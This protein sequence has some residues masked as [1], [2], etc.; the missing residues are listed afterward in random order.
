MKA[1]ILSLIAT[2]VSIAATEAPVSKL[3]NLAADGAAVAAPYNDKGD[4]LPDFSHAGYG[5]G[6][7][8][9]PQVPVAIT[10]SPAP[11]DNRARIQAAL[12]SLAARAPDAEGW[13]GALWLRRGHYAV[14]GTLFIRNSGVVLRGEGSGED[15]T[16][17]VATKAEKH[18]LIE[19]GGTGQWQERKESSVEI[20]DDYVPVGAAELNVAGAGRFHPGDRVIVQ[21]ASNARWIA[22]IGMDHIPPR[23][24]GRVVYQWQPGAMDLMFDRRI[25]AVEGNRLV[26]DVPLANAFQREFGG[27]RVYRYDFPGRLEHIGVEH[28]RCVSRFDPAVRED[29]REGPVFLRGE[30]VDEDHA[31]NAVVF[32]A[33]E[34]AWARDVVSV[35]FANACVMSGR[36]AGRVTVAGCAALDPVSRLTGDRRYAFPISGQLVLVRDCYARKARH[37]FVLDSRVPGPNVYLDCRAEENYSTSEPH[38]RWAAGGLWDNVSVE[39]PGAWL[40]AVNRGWMGT[41]HGWAGAQMVFW[42]CSAALITVLQPPTAQNFAVGITRTWSQPKLVA[43]GVREADSTARTGYPP[44]APFWGDGYRESEVGPVAPRSLYQAQLKA[45]M[46]KAPPAMHE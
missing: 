19:A 2:T 32:D 9:L 22:A 30:R 4:R 39:G 15:G 21:R 25:V 37:A 11:G 41:G 7:V 10:L 35:A 34:D 26:L 8:P 44:S 1:L 14:E 45:R 3:V 43:A 40:S 16:V 42:N 36:T 46:R 12:D 6:G 5:G 27:G 23:P 20:T 24:D 38:H 33:V 18:N 29:A 13:R 31:W 28:L 17:L